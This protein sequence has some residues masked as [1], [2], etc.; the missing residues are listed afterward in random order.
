MRIRLRGPG[1]AAN[2]LF[3][4]RATVQDLLAEAVKVA[5]S[6][7]CTLLSGFP[8]TPLSLEPSARLADVVQNG[9]TL[10]VQPSTSAVIKQPT[11]VSQP[12]PEPIAAP[13]A[14]TSA[15][16][17]ADAATAPDHDDDADLRLALALSRGE[18][19]S[20]HSGPMSQGPT[21][22]VSAPSQLGGE[23]RMVKRVIPADNSCL[24]A[25]VAHA[26]EGG[27]GCTSAKKRELREHVAAAV[28]AGIESGDE[29]FGEAMLGRRPV[30]Y[31]D[32]IRNE[33]HWGGATELDIL[34]ERYATEL[35][36]IDVKTGARKPP[37]HGRQLCTFPQPHSRPFSACPCVLWS[38]HH[39]RP[40]VVRSR[41]LRPR[42]KEFTQRAFCYMREKESASFFLP[43]HPCIFCF[44]CRFS[45]L[46]LTPS[47]SGRADTFGQGRGYTQRALLLYDGIH[48]DLLVRT[49]FTGAP[50]ELDVTVFP[51]GDDQAIEQAQAVAAEARAAR[52]FTD[53]GSFTLRCLVCQ[54]GLKG[55]GEAMEHAKATA[56][57]N[58]SE[59]R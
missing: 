20:P 29:R 54:K 6:E 18:D 53:T 57:T 49:L 21:Q 50:A 38:L 19:I 1:G 35:A 2:C 58:F 56:H 31:A 37:A 8:P 48:Y 25:A 33:E 47:S 43:G 14:A 13:P 41:H 3:D 16:A 22:R 44:S 12:A 30:E 42:P 52:E 23:E 36:A 27:A 34:S 26:L 9:D 4:E 17:R 32:W 55:E 51:V 59:Y 15:G 46:F 10:T 39:S 24:F 5:Q 45:S 40:F 28:L 7:H 11:S